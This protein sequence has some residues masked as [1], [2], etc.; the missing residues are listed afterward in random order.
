MTPNGIYA[1]AT[2]GHYVVDTTKRRSSQG[3]EAWGWI[4]LADEAFLPPEEQR[5]ASESFR[6]VLSTSR[7]RD[8]AR[9][10]GQAWRCRWG[11]LSS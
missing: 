2:A 10:R 8:P 6:R 1:K 7:T 3:S 5:A 11:R 9:A 4:G